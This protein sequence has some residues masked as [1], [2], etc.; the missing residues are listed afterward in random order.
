MNILLL[1]CPTGEG[2]NSA[3]RAIAEELSARGIA[4][5]SKDPV[6]FQSERACHFVSSFYNGMV[7]KAPAAFGALY[8]AGGLYSATGVRS[9]VY[10]A[11]AHYAEA[12]YAYICEKRF[13]AVVCTHLYGM[14]ALT[15]IRRRLQK[16]VFSFGVLTDYTCIPFFWEVELDGYFVPHASIGETLC[17][18]GVPQERIFATGIPVSSRFRAHI[19]KQT[20]RQLLGLPP[21]R[22]LYL[23]MTGGVG[24]ETMLGLCDELARSDGDAI[25][26]VLTGRNGA[27]LEKLCARYGEN[28][29]I[30]AVGFTDQVA[31][32][33]RACD[34]LIS[35]PGGLSSTE[36]AVANVPLVHFGAIPGCETRNAHFFS[37]R[38]LS[39]A[40]RRE[41]EAA[42]AAK[43]LADRA[44]EAKRMCERQRAAIP[45]DASGQIV[46]RI[47][48]IVGRYAEQNNGE[49][50]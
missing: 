26:Y 8:K 28:G 14:E 7:R 15:A 41:K 22:R 5:E 32:Y 21:D 47:S 11:N 9:P 13:D 16:Q 4:W 25:A 39:L 23:L 35:K 48:E 3:S 36:A 10:L 38:G 6:S 24:C 43:E 1:S 19:P 45:A 29:C 12:L 37:S 42:E 34:V 50:T 27:L 20:A 30:R 40:V 31:V 46:E 2:H 18:Q 44:D 49:T 33:M 17:G